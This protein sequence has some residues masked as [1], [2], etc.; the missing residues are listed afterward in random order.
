MDQYE[1]KLTDVDRRR[2]GSL[3]SCEEAA[4]YGSLHSRAELEARLEEA[5]AIPVA[6]TPPTLVTMNSTVL[7]ADVR[8]GERSTCTLV[9][10]EDRDL[11]PRSVGVFQSGQCLLG[12]SVGDIVE[13]PDQAKSTRFKIE[14]V[15]YQ[16]ETAGAS[17]L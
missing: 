10:P 13:M 14:S 2:L 1:M 12:R 16:P 15:I 6:D 17:H 5:D 7:L 9:Y 11:V 4:A 8:T 3:L